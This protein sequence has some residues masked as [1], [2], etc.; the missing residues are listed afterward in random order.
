MFLI[1]LRLKLANKL[2]NHLLY[3]FLIQVIEPDDAV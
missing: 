1:Q 2:I 3:H